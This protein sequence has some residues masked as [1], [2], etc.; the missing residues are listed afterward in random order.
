MR[1]K[2]FV[3]LFFLGM[4]ALTA[5]SFGQKQ[6][7]EWSENYLQENISFTDL[8]SREVTATTVVYEVRVTDHRKLLPLPVGFGFNGKVFADNGRGYD[9]VS[10]DGIYT[11]MEAYPVTA[12]SARLKQNPVSIIDQSFKYNNSVSM[13]QA[14]ES[15]SDGVL[16][17]GPGIKI[18]CKFKKCGCPCTNG[19]TC[20]ACEWWGW[21]CIMIESCEVEVAF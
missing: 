7:M 20:T 14:G 4:M 9:R 6:L 19:K 13:K 12:G 8:K 2:I 3:Q 18:K 17:D 11:T 21:Q 1:K 5:D 15:G 16:D 10:G